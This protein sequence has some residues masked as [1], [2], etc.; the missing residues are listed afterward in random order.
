MAD[1]TIEKS[2]ESSFLSQ[3]TSWFSD[4]N[5]LFFFLL[6]VVFFNGGFG[7]GFCGP[8]GFLGGLFADP[9][10]LFMLLLLVVLFVPGIF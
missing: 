7:K 2:G 1:Q 5:L 4:S 9:S 10:L 8:G 6:V 3:M